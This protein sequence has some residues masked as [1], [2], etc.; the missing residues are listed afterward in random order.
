MP[1]SARGERNVR[2]SVIMMAVVTTVTLATAGTA[3]A[4]E[5]PPP[6]KGVAVAL[7]GTTAD[8]TAVPVSQPIVDPA[9]ATCYDLLTPEGDAADWAEF[10]NRTDRVAAVSSRNCVQV[11]TGDLGAE[12]TLQPG[13]RST[14]MVYRSV[15][16]TSI[17]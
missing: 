16:F 9:L 13:Q 10:V 11:H 8:G 4:G 7:K 12:R 15:R 17:P 14:D 6:A 3:G 5:P 2:R 1:S